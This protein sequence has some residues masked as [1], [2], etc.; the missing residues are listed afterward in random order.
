MNPI[1]IDTGIFD[2]PI[3]IQ[4]PTQSTIVK[5]EVFIDDEK[6]VIIDT[7][8]FDRPILLQK[9]KF[10]LNENSKQVS[11]RSYVVQEGDSEVLVEEVVYEEYVDE[12][13]E[14]DKV[15]VK[16]VVQEVEVEGPNGQKV[17]RKV[18]PGEE[19]G[20]E[21]FQ[22]REVIVTPEEP[23]PE[24]RADT[25]CWWLFA[26]P[27]SKPII[28]DTGI[29]DRPILIQDGVEPFQPRE[30]AVEEQKPIIID[31]GIF[32]RPILI[33]DGVES[34][35]PREIVVEEQKPIIIDTG[36]FDRPIL[37][38]DGVE[39]FQP[40]EVVVAPEEPIPE[41]RADTGCWWLFA[42][43]ESKPIIIDTGIFDRPILIQDG[44][45]PFQPREIVVEEQKPI[46]IDTG[47]FDRPILIQD[48]VEPFQPREVIVAPEEPIPE[49]RADTGCWWLFA[50]PESK[51]IIIDTGIFDRPILIQ[52]GVEPFQPRE[53]VVAP[54]E[55]IPECRA[56]TGCWWLFAKPE[57]KPIIIDTGI[58]DRPI[59]IQDGVEPFQPR[60][61]V[62]APEEPI[63]EC[64]ADT[65]CWWLF[66]KPE[67]TELQPEVN[68]RNVEVSEVEDDS[69][70]KVHCKLPL[71]YTT[72][73]WVPYGSRSIEVLTDLPL[74][75]HPENVWVPHAGR[76]VEVLS[77][78]PLGYHPENVWVP[79]AGRSVEVLSDLPLGYHPEN[80][81]VPHAGR[82]VEVLSDL[83]LGYTVPETKQP[84]EV[85]ENVERSIE[86]PVEEK[87][88][89]N[90]E[91]VEQLKREIL[92]R[93]Q[94]LK[95]KDDELS[96][97]KSIVDKKDS[98][99]KSQNTDYQNLIKLNEELN[100]KLTQLN[101][102]NNKLQKS[103]KV[104]SLPTP[105]SEEH[106]CNYVCECGNIFD[107]KEYLQNKLQD[108]YITNEI[109]SKNSEIEKLTGKIVALNQ[110]LAVLTLN[111]DEAEKKNR[112]TINNLK[113]KADGYLERLVKLNS[114]VSS[115]TL[116]VDELKKN[117]AEVTTTEKNEASSSN[118]NDKQVAKRVVY[119]SPESRQI[120]TNIVNKA[121]AGRCN[122]L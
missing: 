64:R 85:V 42:K 62:V 25:G 30:V 51:P 91:L 20:V 72:K 55:P 102:M 66:A 120:I 16:E 98:E 45:E 69:I 10:D 76:S 57:S 70:L 29:F 114:Q 108:V 117:K 2:R 60:E 54:E 77:D 23:I 27:E 40:R 18:I 22:P 15:I 109:K 113:S 88:N 105:P 100:H 21:P 39:P 7:G 116:L 119:L 94:L 101:I 78:L 12:E 1:I 99:I 97:L 67:I 93:D 95:K 107:Q 24:C 9:P 32:D 59:L 121:T 28:I 37:I 8:I 118:T 11:Q 17:I 115:L 14:G 71:G 33:Q 31:T 73:Q 68:E 90:D 83:P 89:S 13:G 74:G 106:D 6:P 50:K 110:Q 56:D 47:I 44:V 104:D 103:V 3:L 19:N 81:W 41:C 34:F 112:N 86:G 43:P 122:I 35:Q 96:E 92:V 36:I 26:K 48:G 79:H 65:G 53:V 84:A 80:V 5:E 52:D 58:F 63:P 46:I 82:S 61:V 38:Q 49:C 87:S 4:N 75:Y 111:I